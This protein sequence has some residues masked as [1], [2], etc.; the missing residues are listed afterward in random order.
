MEKTNGFMK[1]FKAE[2]ASASFLIGGMMLMVGALPMTVPIS[3][4]VLDKLFDCPIH[5]NNLKEVLL[6]SLI[7]G[8]FL[9][10]M[11]GIAFIVLCFLETMRKRREIQ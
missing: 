11:T 8:L 7:L 1:E 10:I 6:L 3:K 5:L 2:I 4:L 9:A